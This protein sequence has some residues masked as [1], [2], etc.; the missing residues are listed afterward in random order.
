MTRLLSISLAALALCACSKAP[1]PPPQ[2]AAPAPGPAAAPAVAMASTPEAK[3]A[4][5]EGVGWFAGDVDAAFAQAKASGKPLFLYWG[6]TW[7]PPC[8]QVKA[9]IFNRQDFIERSKNFVAVYVDGDKPSAQKIATRFKVSG[10]PTMVLFRPDGSEVTRL[11]GEVDA[12][13]YMRVLAMGMGGARP[14][15]ESIAAALAAPAAKGGATLGADDWRLLAFYSWAT[16][17]SQAVPEKDVAPTLKRLA[18]ACPGDQAALCTRLELQAIAATATA[19]GAKPSPN[20]AAAELLMRVTADPALARENFDLL[21]NYAGKMAGHV[22]AA[23]SVPRRQLVNAWNAALDRMLADPKLSTLDRLTAINAKVELAEVD[24]ATKALSPELIAAVREEVKRA[25]QTTDRYEREAAIAA[26]ADVLAQAGLL[27]ESD[28]LLNAELARSTSPY[29]LMLGLASNA[30]KR[31][32]GGAALDWYEKAHA[33]SVGQA[34]RLQWGAIYVSELIDLA[35]ADNARIE[36]AVA[37]VI[38]ELDANPDTFQGRNQRAL[39]RIGRKLT[40]W[41][42]AKDCKVVVSRL[43]TRMADVCGKLPAGDPARAACNGA[44]NPPKRATG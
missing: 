18:Q 22:T 36:R 14:V 34:T 16:D 25:A 20:A 13:Q 19:R 28:A 21:G 42:S 2:A 29:Y 10:Y 26:A 40:A 1:E 15:K 7:C 5:G 43:S 37:S 9:T 39:E 6:A 17:Q 31:G 11:P 33:A 35:P 8:N 4:A 44:L 24:G 23:R 38:A 41:N 3:P 27:G 12:D 30:K 32:N